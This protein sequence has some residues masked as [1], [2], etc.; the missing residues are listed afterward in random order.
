M[1]RARDVPRKTGVLERALGEDER[2]PGEVGDDERRSRHGSRRT[3]RHGRQPLRRAD[4]K[5]RACEQEDHAHNYKARQASGYPQ[6]HS[7][8][9]GRNRLGL[10]PHH[11]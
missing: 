9:I 11:E 1:D 3:L 7:P 10:K 2:L 5:S 8:R 4:G 6:S